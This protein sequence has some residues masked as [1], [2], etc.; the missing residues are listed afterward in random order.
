[1]F[2]FSDEEA[3]STGGEVKNMN[4][5]KLR[6]LAEEN[7]VDVSAMCH[8]GN[9]T[10][11]FVVTGDITILPVEAVINPANA[12]LKHDGGLA[13]ALCNKGYFI[14]TLTRYLI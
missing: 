12:R 5:T 6:L 3:K 14:N 13:K 11:I 8:G 10:V 1:M 9:D 4:F 2:R 7:E